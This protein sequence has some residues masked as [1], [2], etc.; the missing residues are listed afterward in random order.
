MSVAPGFAEADA[1]TQL[2]S[3]IRHLYA[4]VFWFGVLAGSLMAFLSIYASR[5]GASGFQ[6]GL[7]SAGPGVINLL[8]SMPAGKWLE[9]RSL[10]R[11]TYLS[12]VL[13]RVMYLAMIPLPW[14]LVETWQVWGIILISLV[15]AI[16][17]TFLAIAFNAVFAEVVPTEKRAEVVGRRNALVAVSMTVT[18]LLSGLIL[19]RLPFPLNYQVVFTIGAFGALL[20]SYHLGQLQPL[21]KARVRRLNRLLNDFARPGLMRFA[22]TFRRPVGLR[23]LTRTGDS[24]VLRL[25]LLRGSFGPFLGALLFFYTVQYVPVPLFPLYFVRDLNLSDG[26]IGW[27]S[28]LFH[29]MMFLASVFLAR[30]NARFSHRRLLVYGALFYCLYPMIMGLAQDSRLFILAS[31][32]GGAVWAV[33]NGGLVNRL[34]ERVPEGDRP[35]HM[36][37]HNIALNLGILAGSLIGPLIADWLGLR[38]AILLSSGLRFLGGLL[39]LIWG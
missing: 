27:G 11:E 24:S 38:E 7:L 30:L 35:G 23:F 13:H 12:S 19:D 1:S 2:R 6:I 31:I 4:D 34:M 22:D 28:A 33:T 9:G 18:T 20:S 21:P 32:L 37:L 26:L 25:D 29:V 36:A 3:T 15:M 8:I 17:G 16:P 5:I 10:I 39:I 14:L